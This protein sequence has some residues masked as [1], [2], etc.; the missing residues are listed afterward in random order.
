MRPDLVGCLAEHGCGL[1]SLDVSQNT[2]LKELICYN[3]SLTSLDVSTNTALEL[4]RCEYNT[5]TSLTVSKTNNTALKDVYCGGNQISGA[6]MTNL[7]NGLPTVTGDHGFNVCDDT[8][9]TDNV[10]TPAQV[11]TATDKGWMVLKFNGSWASPYA[12][13]G[14]VDGDNKINQNDVTLIV[15]IIM[16][17]KPASV[18]EYAGD[19]NMDGKTDAA[20]I[21]VMVNILK[22]LGVK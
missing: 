13:Y 15:N 8:Q 22:A 7:V 21:V 20:D 12:G 18:G 16:G 4:L 9:K 17:Q 6:A 1:T 14:D 19:L 11:K 5:L 3:N 10:I 2:A